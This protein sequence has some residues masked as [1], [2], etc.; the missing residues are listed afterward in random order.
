MIFSKV[1]FPQ[2]LGPTIATYSPGKIWKEMLHFN[3]S[4]DIILIII[5]LLFHLILGEVIDETYVVNNTG[6][7]MV[8]VV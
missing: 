6:V 1:D 4:N 5:I 8:L 7:F 2:P 3:I